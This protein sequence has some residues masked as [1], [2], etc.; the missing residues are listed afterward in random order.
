MKFKKIT[1]E[2]NITRHYYKCKNLDLVWIHYRNTYIYNIFIDCDN[3]KWLYNKKIFNSDR[4]AD[5]K[6]RMFK[7]SL[8]YMIKN[9]RL[10]GLK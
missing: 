5:N 4:R 1:D 8:L 6:S 9:I 3:N 7:Y 2:Y 10:Y